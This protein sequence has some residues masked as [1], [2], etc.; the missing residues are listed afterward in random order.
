MKT[1]DELNLPQQEN[2][3][4]GDK[5]AMKKILNK[6]VVVENYRIVPSKYPDKGN[7]LRLDLQISI[8]EEKHITWTIAKGLQDTIQ[9]IPKTSLPFETT[10]VSK[11]D[12]Y[13]FT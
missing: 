11:N 1:F 7:P 8:G 12:K 5:I 4:S 6:K 10:I 9:K 3:F 2:G 13:F